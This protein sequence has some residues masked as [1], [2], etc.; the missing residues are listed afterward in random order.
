VRGREL[1]LFFKEKAIKKIIKTLK[2][3]WK[4]KIL[5]LLLKKR[6]NQK[7]NTGSLF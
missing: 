6:K 7:Q 3:L 5:I 1:F 2:L 4:N